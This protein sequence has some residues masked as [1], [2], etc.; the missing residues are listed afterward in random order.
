[1]LLRERQKE[2][3]AK[4]VT[5]LIANDNTLGVAPTGA[6]KT[7]CLSAVIGELIKRNPDLKAC[8]LAHRDELTHQNEDKFKLVNPS[9]STSILNSRCKSWDGQVTFA[10]VQTLSREHNLQAMPKLDLLVIDE[11]HHATAESYISILNQATSLNPSVKI[12]G[13]TATP[14]RGDKSSLGKIFTN[15]ADQ[16]KL[17]E[18]I[19]SGLL[20]RPKTWIID[21]GDTQEKL[22]ALRTRSNSDFNNE[23]MAEILDVELL[24]SEVVRHWQ[25]KAGSRQTVVFCSNSTH[26]KNITQ[27]FITAGVKTGLVSC[28]IPYA[29]RES[30]LEALKQGE[31]QVI[32]NVAVLTEGWDYPPISCVVLLRSSSYKATLIQMIGRGLRTI[33]P[34]IYP[35]VIKRDCIVLDFGISSIIHGSLEQE[36]DLNSKNEGL[37][38]C[39]CCKQR[40]SKAL[41]NCTS[42]G[43]DLNLEHEKDDSI[44]TNLITSKRILENFTMAEINLL[45]R[46]NFC[47][48]D[49]KKDSGAIIAAGFNSWCC[50]FKKGDIWF[51]I[52]GGKNNKNIPEIQTKIVYQG[53]RLEAIAAANDFLYLFEDEETAQKTNNWKNLAPSDAQKNYLP[54][55][56]K[57]GDLTRGDA[58]AIIT[59]SLNAQHKLREI[60]VVL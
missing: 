27:A 41:A 29:E 16:I 33:D 43:A 59:Y 20:V 38:I 14:A 13:V 6:G 32:V 21:T 49:L 3:V 34:A 25:E 58:A 1:M 2:F 22:K 45:E 8:V 57:E 37:K 24:N 56:F 26:A 30:I 15:C 7:I 35:D 55:E 44:I 28:D 54:D 9:I 48:T 46:S 11:A 12:F 4:S 31:I 40:T 39:A 47:W 10:M 17:R 18:L 53:G 5:A 36:L 60:G 19:L 52:G 51:A 42:C 50:I 23:E